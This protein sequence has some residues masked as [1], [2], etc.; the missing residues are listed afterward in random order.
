MTSFEIILSLKKVIV[1]FDG[2]TQEAVIEK[3]AKTGKA[4]E[5]WKD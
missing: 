2:I 1:R 3:V 5:L 4:T